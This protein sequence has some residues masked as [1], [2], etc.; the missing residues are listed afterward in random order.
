MIGGGWR[1]PKHFSRGLVATLEIF[2][3]GGNKGQKGH[4]GCAQ[5]QGIPGLYSLM[6]KG[7]FGARI[8]FRDSRATSPGP[9]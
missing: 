7:L 2:R 9:Y 6:F 4:L 8:K 1:T 3:F 5:P